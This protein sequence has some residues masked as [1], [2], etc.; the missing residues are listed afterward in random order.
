MKMKR[1]VKQVV[2]VRGEDDVE[3]VN[4]LFAAGYEA[5][6]VCPMSGGV[7]VYLRKMGEGGAQCFLCCDEDDVEYVNKLLMETKGNRFYINKMCSV[8]GGVFM[9]M[10]KYPK[11][12]S[13]KICRF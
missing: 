11:L 13:D 12:E 1:Q 7:I 6:R 8:E 9:V 5:S 3:Y 2:W 4:K 10:S